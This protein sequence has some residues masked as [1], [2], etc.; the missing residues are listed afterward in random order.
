MIFALAATP[1][2]SDCN[3][4]GVRSA[5][6]V[7]CGNAVQGGF[8]YGET[9]YFVH[10]R[11]YDA[12]YKNKIFVLGL[13]MD[14]DEKLT[15]QFCKMPFNNGFANC[16]SF[17]YKVKQRKYAEQNIR[18]DDKFIDYPPEIQKRID[19]ENGRMASA[20]KNIDPSFIGF[21]NWKY[22]FAK[23]YPVSGSYGARRVFNGE[24]KS[25]HRG[26][27]IAAPRGTKIRAVGVGKVVLTID[28]Y[29]SG[30]TVIISH[31]FGIFSLY[32]HLNKI[33]AAT[34]DVVGPDSIIG[35]VGSTGR[36]SGPHLHLGLY[37][38]RTPIDAG[39]FF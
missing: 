10:S 12:V 2:F 30:K 7:L 8:L 24:R 35:T 5:A 14:A 36:A 34:G 4:R 1:A 3:V 38:N 39:L 37:F 19:L 9:D 6:P 20:M 23:K 27:D 29:M 17:D 32:A 22:P 21:M 28:S 33:I 11:Q 16:Q 15:L 26:L 31:G 25:P 18:V 13:P